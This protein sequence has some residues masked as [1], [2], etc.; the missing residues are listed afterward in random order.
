MELW[1]LPKRKAAFANF[2]PACWRRSCELVVGNFQD[3][4]LL[5]N[6][7]LNCPPVCNDGAFWGWRLAKSLAI[8]VSKSAS[9]KWASVPWNLSPRGIRSDKDIGCG[10]QEEDVQDVDVV[11]FPFRPP[12]S[13]VQELKRKVCTVGRDS[14]GGNEFMQE[15]SAFLPVEPM[16][17]RKR[18]LKHRR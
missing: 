17:G 8:V 16:S 9:G 6:N 5:S 11:V 13:K 15:V 18:W 2:D 3:A 4:I 12:V 10:S 7:L 14:G 1:F